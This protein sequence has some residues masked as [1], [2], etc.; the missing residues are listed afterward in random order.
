MI[1]TPFALLSVQDAESLQELSGFFA[2]AFIQRLK[3]LIAARGL[4]DLTGDY[5]WYSPTQQQ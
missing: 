4:D 2:K 5:I 1:K 3:Q